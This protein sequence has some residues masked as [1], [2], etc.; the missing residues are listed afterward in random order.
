MNSLRGRLLVAAGVALLLFV[1]ITALALER[2]DHVRAEQAVRD[3]LQGLVYGVLSIIEVSPGGDIDIIEGNLPDPRFAQFESGL[4]AMLAETDGNILW[5][6]TSLLRDP[7]VPVAL[8]VGA[9]R[10]NSPTPD[11]PY[12]SLSLGVSWG[13][14]KGERRFTVIVVEDSATFLAQRS[15]FRR[16]LWLWLGTAAVLLLGILLVILYWGLGPVRR[17]TAE[18]RMLQSGR[19]DHIIGHYPDELTPLGNALNSL[20]GNE[21]LRQ[22]RYRLA[23]DDLAHSLKTPLAALRAEVGEQPACNAPIQQMQQQIDYH[24]KRALAGGGKTFG[25]STTLRPL[26]DQTLA[27]LGKVYADKQITF[28]VNIPDDLQ[29]AIER[30][31]LL[32]I[33]GN[34]LDNA[35]KW[36][37]RSVSV[38][39]TLTQNSIGILV[40]DDGPGFPADAIKL[41]DRGIR[42]DTRKEGQGIG[43]A[44]VADIVSS[45]GGEIVLDASRKLGGAAVRLVLH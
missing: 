31:D 45:L 32:E 16:S 11:Y 12:F 20:I 42:A 2:A 4:G 22:S 44:L 3:R 43:L 18:V 29:L 34:L 28:S 5:R 15:R 26:V 6:T 38:T 30:G 40:E 33:M 24:L 13:L 7:P 35:C 14:E 39:A 10:L 17:L 8:P 25:Q 23:L 19:Q 21:R 9:W 37:K 41:L 36:C 1:L 27:A